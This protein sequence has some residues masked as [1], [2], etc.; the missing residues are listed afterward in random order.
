MLELLMALV[1]ADV[2]LNKSMHAFCWI[3]ILHLLIVAYI[4]RAET[5]QRIEMSRLL[6]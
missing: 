1:S 2:L 5:G 6:L 4:V 3:L